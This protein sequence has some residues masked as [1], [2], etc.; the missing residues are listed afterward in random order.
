M[1][2][3]KKIKQFAKFLSYILERHPEEFGLIPDESG[4]VKIKDL[5]KALNETDGWRHI[6]ESSL[7]ELML[8]ETMPPVEIKDSL[9]RAV[10]RQNLPEPLPCGQ[11]PKLLYTCVREKAYPHA[12][13]K[14]IFP[15]G[16]DHVICTPDKHMAERLGRR[17]DKNAVLLTI[18]AA[19]AAENNISF[20]QFTDLFFLADYIP[21]DIFT[22][23]PLP[24][25]PEKKVAAATPK[26]AAPQATHGTYLVTPEMIIP[27]AGKTAKGKKKKLDWKQERKHRRKK[28]KNTWP[29]G[30]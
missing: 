12:L 27:T 9:I 20:L 1:T 8:V 23:P 25:K 4:Y 13:E 28:D 11:L 19:K 26:P 30:Y 3:Q 5:L 22:G 2:P 29:D 7:N 15:A 18:H 17:K 6:R 14:G 21:P 10:D 16:H 24:K